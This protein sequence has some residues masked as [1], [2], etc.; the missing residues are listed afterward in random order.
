MNESTLISDGESISFIEHKTWT[1]AGTTEAEA[2][3]LKGCMVIDSLVTIGGV[4]LIML[5]LYDSTQHFNLTDLTH[6][7]IAKIVVNDETGKVELHSMEV[8]KEQVLAFK[9]SGVW[10]E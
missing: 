10:F 4:Y 1:A 9:Q 7:R 6:F 3:L 5:D 2:D 8:T